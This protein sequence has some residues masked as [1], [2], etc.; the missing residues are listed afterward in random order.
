MEATHVLPCGHPELALVADKDDIAHDNG[1][2]LYCGLCA[3]MRGLERSMAYEYAVSTIDGL[4]LELPDL[5]LDH[6]HL[7]SI[8]EDDEGDQAREAVRY[9]EWRGLIQRHEKN[10]EWVGILDECEAAR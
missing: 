10:P 3:E 5:G 6:Y 7:G 9:L 1:V 2:T 4:C 8:P